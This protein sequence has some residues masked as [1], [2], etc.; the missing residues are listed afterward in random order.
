MN[1]EFI[2]EIRNHGY[3]RWRIIL[4]GIVFTHFWTRQLCSFPLFTDD[5]KFLVILSERLVHDPLPTEQNYSR[6]SAHFVPAFHNL[7]FYNIAYREEFGLP[8]SYISASTSQRL[9]K[10]ILTAC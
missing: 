5:K 8:N 9:E 10:H 4:F 6:L 2:S 7:H 1:K 3:L